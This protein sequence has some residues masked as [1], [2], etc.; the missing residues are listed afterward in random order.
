MGAKNWSDEELKM[1]LATINVPKGTPV[2]TKDE[3]RLFLTFCDRTGLD[4][5]A[6]QAYLIPRGG[7]WR[8]ETSVD[9]L[10]CVAMKSGK[11]MGQDGPYWCGEDGHWV[12]IW[13][14]KDPP[15]AAKVGVYRA[16]FD[17]PTYGVVRLDQFLPSRGLYP[18][19]PWVRMPDIMLAKVAESQALR[20][21]FPVEL[22]G[23]YSSEEMAQALDDHTTAPVP[24]LAPERRAESKQEP[25][26]EPQRDKD[27]DPGEA[28]EADDADPDDSSP[29]T[30]DEKRAFLNTYGPGTGGL[31]IPKELLGA[32]CKSVT[33]RP[34]F[35]E[36][37][38][39][40]YDV[41][42]SDDTYSEA[43]RLIS[44]DQNKRLHGIIANH[45]KLSGEC[46]EFFEGYGIKIDSMADM[47][48]W[49]A[50]VA[51]ECFSK[52]DFKS[53]KK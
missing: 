7:K 44:V 3:V 43:S 15:F 26:Q 33:G 46:K 37:T 17:K 38:R 20:K 49:M 51:I 16:G 34:S 18:D 19:S 42:M 48:H 4:Y 27:D 52:P 50:A 21:S 8:A 11:Y 47:K 22:S 28:S 13:T 45:E 40:T 36:Q 24:A 53:K 5:M 10:R 6:R 31:G 39:K 14:K 12:D 1:A 35:A 25:K 41:L 32:F 9:G 30:D 2:P 29:L 23:V